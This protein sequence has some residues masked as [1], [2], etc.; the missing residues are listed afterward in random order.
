[1]TTVTLQVVFA[2]S[3]AHESFIDSIETRGSV[4]FFQWSDWTAP[5]SRALDTVGTLVPT[6]S[7]QQD[8]LLA[9]LQGFGLM[10]IGFL[11]IIL[12]LISFAFLR[13]AAHNND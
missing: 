10:F 8:A 5:A 11:P 3:A 7:L 13:R 6:A 2:Y 12:M 1:M 9:F 4:V